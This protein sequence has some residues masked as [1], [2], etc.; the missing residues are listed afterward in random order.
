MHHVI[1]AAAERPP[2]PGVDDVEHQRRVDRDRRV[3]AR[4][5]LP[6]A[7][8]H[9]GHELAVASRSGAAA[10]SGR[11]RSRRAGPAV[12]PAT[13]HLQPLDRRIDVAGGAAG[14]AFLAE[15]VPRL[16]RLPQLE[17]DAARADVAEQREAELEVRREPLGARADSRRRAAPRAR[18]RSPAATKCGSMKRS[19]SS[20]PQRTS[21]AVVGRRARTA[22][23]A[24]AAAVA[25]PG[26]SARAAA[27]RTPAARPARAGRTA[28]SGEYSLSMQNSARC[29]L[30][31]TSISRWRKTRSTSHGGHGVGRVRESAR[32]RSPAR[33]RCRGAPRRRAAP[34]SSGR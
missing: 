34:G 10:P 16:E 9:A 2:D 1:L 3:Q 31:V 13:L 32:R 21:G 4:R 30:P 24:R 18:P 29:V 11:C 17:L 14:R 22:R 8:A 15:H 12:R 28:M 5:R 25:A 20:V 23:R 19:C 27:S 33:R 26:S 6:G 7:V